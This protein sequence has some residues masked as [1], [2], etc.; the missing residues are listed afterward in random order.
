M[1]LQTT[2]HLV[3]TKWFT[4]I[5]YTAKV[6]S[7]TTTTQEKLQGWYE[8]NLSLLPICA[9]YIKFKYIVVDIIVVKFTTNFVHKGLTK[10]I[11]DIHLYESRQVLSPSYLRWPVRNLRRV[12]SGQHVTRRKDGLSPGHKGTVQRSADTV[13]HSGLKIKYVVITL[14]RREES[15]IHAC[16]IHKYR[17]I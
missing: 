10:I 17:Y 11:H 2:R 1:S 12:T 8:A 9:V 14:G 13:G 7:H 3:R 6:L 16:S 4:C 5:M 15:D